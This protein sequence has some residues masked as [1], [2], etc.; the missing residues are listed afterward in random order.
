MNRN[1]LHVSNYGFRLSVSQMGVITPLSVNMG[2]LIAIQKTRRFIA[3]AV[4]SL[5]V[6][7]WWRS[8]VQQ[9]LPVFLG[10]AV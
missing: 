6:Q 2:L 7:E 5:S 4:N 8:L 9:Y 10:S 3:K 1:N